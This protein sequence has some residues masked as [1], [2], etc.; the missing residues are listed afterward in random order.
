MRFS[1][2]VIL[3]TG[4]NRGI[5]FATANCF[6]LEGA[7]VVIAARNKELGEAKASEIGGKFVQTDVT[8]EDE[9]KNLIDET[10]KAF[11][12]IDV[13]VNCAGIIYRNKTAEQTTVEEWDN[14]FNT[15]M[16][17]MFMITKYAI[18]ELRKTKGSVINLS[19]YVGLVGFKGSAAYAASKAAIIN[20]SRSVA[21][22]HAKEGIRVN[23]VCPG[24]VA[25]DM[26]DKAWLEFG[27]VEE[28]KKLWES[29]HPMGRIAAPEEVAKTILFLASSDASFITGAAIPVDGGI[30]AE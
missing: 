20:F 28:A 17:S 8:K 4:G 12:R 22:D 7:K 6:S 23:C 2:K 3:I 24:S 18:P 29:K 16:K 19:S 5:G 9:C 30:T 14:I 26:I 15:N 11:G 25:T 13:L 21:L 27:N 10:V 1:D